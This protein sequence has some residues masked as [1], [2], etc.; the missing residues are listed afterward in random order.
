MSKI[1]PG[2]LP[3]DGWNDDPEAVDWRNTTEQ[4][5]TSW[6]QKAFVTMNRLRSVHV[7]AAR[8]YKDQKSQEA[9]KKVT[10]QIIKR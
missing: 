6:K 10:Q 1:Q 9:N 5:C 3:K 7:S 8:G 2:F 4:K